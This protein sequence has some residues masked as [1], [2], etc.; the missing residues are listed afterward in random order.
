MALARAEAVGRGASVA[1]VFARERRGL[2]FRA[3]QDGNRNGVLTADIADGVDLPL[4]PAVRLFELFPGV[5][6]GVTPTADSVDP[7][8]I[9]GTDILTFTPSG[10]S[11]AGTIYLSGRDGTQWGVRVL[12]ATARARVL[13]YDPRLRLWLEPVP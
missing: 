13:R 2:S 12:G 10:T 5:A 1:L 8:R 3:Y 4:E 9:G 7:I 11:S 6:I